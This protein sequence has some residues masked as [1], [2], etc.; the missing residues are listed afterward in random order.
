M[1]THYSPRIV[2]DG[3]ILYLDAANTKS[4]PGTG[5]AWYDLSGNS[6]NGLLVNSP[7]FSSVDRGSIAFN[8]STQSCNIVYPETSLNGDPLFTVEGVFTRTGTYSNM[9]AWGIGGMT[10]SGIC[11]Y[12]DSSRPN[13]IAIDLWG[14][15]TFD[16]SVDYPL[17][18]PVHVAW[19]KYAPGFSIN[20]W[21][22]YVDGVQYNSFYVQRGS[23]HTPTLNASTNGLAVGKI[24]SSLAQY[25]APITV[26]T[27][28]V[29]NKALSAA[30][31]LQNYN[32]LKSRYV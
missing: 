19:V 27:F 1:G 25:Y 32:A 17:N 30:E 10:L 8:G 28:K 7:T 14:T 26:N 16:I 2:T 24:L 9:G 11:A 12:T 5:T 3:L 31:V 23:T 20:S 4:Y 13:K 21:Y 22:I 18:V 15:A 29:Y 6:H